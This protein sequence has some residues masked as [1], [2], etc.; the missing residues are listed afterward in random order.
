[1]IRRPPRST[2]TD[3]LFPYTTLVRAGWARKYVRLFLTTKSKNQHSSYTL[4]YGPSQKPFLPA[5]PKFSETSSPRK[6]LV[7]PKEHSMNA[8]LTDEQTLLLDSVR[9]F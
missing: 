8:I 6:Y 7:C 3:T 5:R 9:R 4:T 1:M 2:R